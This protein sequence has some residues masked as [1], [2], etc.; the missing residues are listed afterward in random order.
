M[1]DEGERPWLIGT[2]GRDAAGVLQFGDQAVVISADEKAQLTGAMDL[3]S[4]LNG[5]ALLTSGQDAANALFA[6]LDE[7]AAHG[8]WLPVDL[9]ASV[10]AA[11][12]AWLGTITASRVALEDAARRYF[13]DDV[14]VSND[15]KSAHADNASFRLAWELRNALHHEGDVAKYVNYSSKLGENADESSVDERIDLASL[16]ASPH[17]RESARTALLSLW[18]PDA[19]PILEDVVR[20]ATD[21]PGDIFAALIGRNEPMFVD[22]LEIIARAYAGAS[23][24]VN[25]VYLYQVVPSAD[26]TKLTIKA[27]PVDASL[28]G[29]I[30]LNVDAARRQAGLEPLFGPATVGT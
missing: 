20:G 3:A 27:R 19:S 1:A 5:N 14:G 15:F 18:G 7:V 13:P 10:A 24:G 9:R 25:A 22:A 2:W 8:S 28:I 26:H 30:A 11:L 21:V 12:G 29:F 23:D 17:L 6:K 4:E 16:L